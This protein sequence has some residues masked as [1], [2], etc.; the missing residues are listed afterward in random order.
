LS[1]KLTILGSSGALP[2]YG[3]FPSSQYLT[4]QNRHFLIDSGEGTQLR[5]MQFGLGIHKID[6]I[7]ISHLHGD[8]YLGLTGLIFSMHLQKREADLHLYSFRGLEEI[9]LAQFKHS[10]SSL[11]FKII[12]HR[13]KEEAVE[14]IFEDD[15]ITVDTIPL[16]HKIHTSGFLFREKMKSLRMDKAK[17]SDAILL[18][19]IVKLKAGEDIVDESGK[20]LF[21]SKD[22]TLP[23]RPSFSYA[24][25]SDT[26]PAESITRQVKGVNILYHEATFLEDE[27]E[28]ARETRHSTA[29]EAATVAKEAGVG[30][31]IIGHFSARYKDLAPVL[32]EAKRVFEHTSLAIEGESFELKD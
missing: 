3:R 31:L 4:I 9:L 21:R 20:V 10:K 25:C 16:V 1:F 22:Y 24:Y 11:N 7:F 14:R 27:K 2:A 18:Q 19:Y 17:L 30:K 13:L 26:Q 32:E 6:H 29:A 12:F 8:H 23:P 15:T 28:K 5:L